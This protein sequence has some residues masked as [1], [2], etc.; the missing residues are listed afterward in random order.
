MVLGCLEAVEGFSKAQITKDVKCCEV[1]IGREIELRFRLA[2]S[3]LLRVY[4]LLKSLDQKVD[5]SDDNGLLRSESACSKGWSEESADPTVLLWVN[6]TEE[7]WRLAGLTAP[8]DPCLRNCRPSAR[9]CKISAYASSLA[10]VTSSGAMRKTGP[11][12]WC[13]FW[14]S[15]LSCQKVIGLTA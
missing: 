13:N 9:D 14:K 15:L 2:S 11:Y 5:I 6:G 7:R 10:K 4:N 1:K 3:P 12:C 8:P